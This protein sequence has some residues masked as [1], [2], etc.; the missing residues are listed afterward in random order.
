MAMRF[1]GISGSLR[2]ASL[3]T[4]LLRA[5]GEVLPEGVSLEI[6]D[7]VRHL[8]LFD[9]DLFTDPIANGPSLAVVS[10][11]RAKL[12]AADAV[13]M[14]LPEYNFSIPGALKN[15]LDWA[16]RN[17][18]PPL[19]DKPLAIMGASAGM[20]G[21]MRAQYHLRQIAV[22]LNMQVLN[23]P[24]VFVAH[25]KAKFDATGRL[26]DE[27]TRLVLAQQMTALRDWTLRLRALHAFE[28]V[29]KAAT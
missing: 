16:S 2:R 19:F 17:P 22:Y 4:A 25:A 10:A 15:A 20:S 27:P 24:E 28:A 14:A 8:P 3:N 18:D 7:E 23:R 9:E 13:V 6:A 11:W 21:A 5:A 12:A 1:V 26:I 29:Q